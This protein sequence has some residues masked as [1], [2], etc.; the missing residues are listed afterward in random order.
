M[1]DPVLSREDHVWH[2]PDGSPRRYLIAPLTRRERTLF[3]RAMVAEGAQYP[4]SAIVWDAMRAALRQLEPTNL[5]E[6]LNVVDAAEA[7]EASSQP[8]EALAQMPPIDRAARS[9]PAYASLIADR[10]FWMDLMP[11]VLAR[12]ALRGWEGPGLPAFAARNGEVPEALME[13]I[14]DDELRGIGN[15]AYDM[16]FVSRS[17]EK[18]SEAP[19]PSAD[20][21]ETGA[22]G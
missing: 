18:N 10:Q 11:G 5:A 12:F 7:E 14:P 2:Q 19:S 1:T 13:A 22:E 4:A 16:A 20:P 15:R 17:A 8:G 6:L 21:P 3:R 9:V